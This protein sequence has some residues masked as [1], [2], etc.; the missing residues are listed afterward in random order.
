MLGA[1]CCREDLL[2]ATLRGER[3]D[4]GGHAAAKKHKEEKKE[5][6]SWSES[7]RDDNETEVGLLTP[8]MEKKATYLAE[9]GN[10]R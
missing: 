9:R 3:R 5:R 1:I 10:T 7:V 8:E 4:K 6:F 2:P